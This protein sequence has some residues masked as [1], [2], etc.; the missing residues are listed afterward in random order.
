MVQVVVL[1]SSFPLLPMDHVMHDSVCRMTVLGSCRTGLFQVKVL[2]KIQPQFPF[3]TT[4][5]YWLGAAK[6]K[7]IFTPTP[8]PSKKFLWKFK[9]FLFYRILTK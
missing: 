5:Q 2:P 7:N 9:S 1:Q 4:W 8:N 3:M 6:L